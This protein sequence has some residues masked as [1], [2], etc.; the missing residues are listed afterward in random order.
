[1]T[2]HSIPYQASF[3]YDFG[4]NDFFHFCG[5]IVY[6]ENY[7]I[8]AAHCCEGQNPGGVQVA[9]GEHN[10]FATDGDEY[11]VGVSEIIIHEDYGVFSY[12]NDICLLRTSGPIM[13]GE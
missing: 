1:M 4:G 6:N 7:V 10:L 12:S 13:M 8:T 2:A 3:Q 9:L 5:G 11:K